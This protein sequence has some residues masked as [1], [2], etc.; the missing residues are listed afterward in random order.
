MDVSSADRQKLLGGLLKV[1]R[2]RID[3]RLRKLGADSY[4]MAVPETLV[5]PLVIR[6]DESIRG[7]VYGRYKQSSGAVGRGV[8]VATDNRLVLI[9]RKV[10]SLRCDEIAYS[11]LAAISYDKV[12]PATTITLH[13]RFGDISI[14]TFNSRCAE[15]FVA[16][17]ESTIF[18]IRQQQASAG[19]YY[20]D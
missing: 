20:L 8:L 10:L 19:Q 13:S 3:D 16:D 6:P 17:M 18:K 4:D 2:E 15:N 11:A 12:G 14:R 1:Y 9:D 7:V 5:L